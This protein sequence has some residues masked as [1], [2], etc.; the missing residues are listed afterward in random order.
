LSERVNASYYVET[1]FPLEDA[2]AA[3]AGEQSTGTFTR[4][5]GETSALRASHGARVERVEPGECRSR[6]SLPGATR[7]HAGAKV[8]RAEIELS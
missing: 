5:A 3:M 4:V 6:P 1:A 7:P 2:A 8:R